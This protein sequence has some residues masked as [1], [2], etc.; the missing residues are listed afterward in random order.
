MYVYIYIYNT[1]VYTYTHTY[2][3]IY[4]YKIENWIRFQGR[5][6]N[7]CPRTKLVNFLT[8]SNPNLSPNFSSI[9]I[10]VRSGTRKYP[11]PLVFLP[12]L[13]RPAKHIHSVIIHCCLGIYWNLEINLFYFKYDKLIFL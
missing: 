2:T 9:P 12:S 13:I 1:C 4:M 11:N 5:D 6:P 8:Y 10:H 7:P 3:Y